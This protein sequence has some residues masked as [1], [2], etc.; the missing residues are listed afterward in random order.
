MRATPTVI[1][2]KAALA[3]PVR[4]SQDPVVPDSPGVAAGSPDFDPASG[5]AAAVESVRGNLRQFPADTR[6]RTSGCRAARP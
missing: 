5:R 1:A 2:R 3:L 6:G 4:V